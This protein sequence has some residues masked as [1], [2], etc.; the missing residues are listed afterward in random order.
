MLVTKMAWTVAHTFSLRL[1]ARA[2]TERTTARGDGRVA[3]P[4]A[5]VCAPDDTQHAFGG[6]LERAE[7]D[8]AEPNS[9]PGQEGE[10]EDGEEELNVEALFVLPE[11]E[12]P[13]WRL[14]GL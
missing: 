6:P 9:R 12:I 10:Q 11:H 2:D 7:G 1:R 13:A 8:E 5:P 14:V 3:S 4:Q